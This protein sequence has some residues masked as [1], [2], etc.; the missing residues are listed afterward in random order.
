MP[1]GITFKDLSNAVFLQ[2]FLKITNFGYNLMISC[3]FLTPKRA[4]IPT[5]AIVV[6]EDHPN[7][8]F[9]EIV[10]TLYNCCGAT[11]VTTISR[12]S[13]HFLHNGYYET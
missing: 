9:N 11:K 1:N 10:I 5:F 8:N 3:S 13:Q 2:F 4:N 12:Q 6:T 7:D